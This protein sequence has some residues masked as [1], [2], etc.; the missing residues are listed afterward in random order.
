MLFKLYLNWCILFWTHQYPGSRFY[1]HFV[2]I[3]HSLTDKVQSMQISNILT[4][5]FFKYKNGFH[6]S[7]DNQNRKSDKSI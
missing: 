2:I 5:V 6:F 4:P 1:V 7:I 3:L